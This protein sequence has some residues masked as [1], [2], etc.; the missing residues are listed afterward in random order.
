MNILLDS[1]AFQDIEG[2]RRLSFSGALDRQLEY[3]DRHG[4]TSKFIVSYDRIVDESPTVQ[5]KRLKRRVG[6][7]T[8][9]KYVD[10]TINAAKY[11][12]DNRKD[13]RPRRLVL[14]NQGVNPNQY[15]G[16]I[17]EVLGFADKDD[18]IGLGGF[19]IVGQIPKYA[20]DYYE[21]LNGLLPKLKARHIHRIHVFGMGVFKILIKTH[22]LCHKYGITPSYD[23]SSL[24]VNA[25]FGKVFSPD[26]SGM[27]PKGIHVSH[28][29]DRKDKYELYH[30]RDWAML[31]IEMVNTF[32]ERMNQLYPLPVAQ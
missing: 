26:V 25:V 1:G 13:L 3:E 15:S 29:F 10:E 16:C 22:V 24:E 32:W 17:E 12:A 9:A 28:V 23:T 8:S 2:D 19:C 7:K 6:P 27:G 11:L 5:G 31:N 21:V 4:F 18:V 20:S 30:P 14:S